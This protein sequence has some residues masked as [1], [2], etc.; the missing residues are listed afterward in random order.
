[1]AN[2]ADWRIVKKNIDFV[3]RGRRNVCQILNTI[4]DALEVHKFARN[5][6]LIFNAE[7]W[8]TQQALIM[9]GKRIQ[10]LRH[11]K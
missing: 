11:G 8:S 6:A 3:I 2:K 4:D 5:L 7:R 9:C 1:M 10:E